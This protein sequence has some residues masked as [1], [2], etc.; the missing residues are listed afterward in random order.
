MIKIV[1]DRDAEG[2][3]LGFMAEGHA[4]YADA[5]EDIVCAAVSAVLQTAVIGL[6]DVL[7]VELDL[8]MDHGDMKVKLPKDISPKQAEGAIVLF[9][10]MRL[11]LESIAMD[12]EEYVIIKNRRKT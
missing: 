9:E 3:I 4:G 5:G 10:T 6:Q 11:G 8:F 2:R 1:F 12:R 7:H